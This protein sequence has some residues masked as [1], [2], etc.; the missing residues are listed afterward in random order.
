M[1]LFVYGTLV[2]PDVQRRVAGRTFTAIPAIL[3]GYRRIEEPERYAF[4]EACAGE[5]VDGAL[6]L[7]VDATSLGRFDDYEDEGHLYHR[8]SVSVLADGN[9][10]TAE[11]YV[12]NRDVVLSSPRD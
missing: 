5:S 10:R 11:A 1:D 3:D 7:D 6:L 9:R 8:R 4:I 2:D 12:G